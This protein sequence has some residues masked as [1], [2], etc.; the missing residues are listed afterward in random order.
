MKYVINGREYPAVDWTKATLG[1]HADMADI[2]GKPL[3]ECVEEDENGEQRLSTTNPKVLIAIL[4]LS[5]RRVDP[6]ATV[7]DARA[8]VPLDIEYVR[9]PGD[10]VDAGP[11]EPSATETGPVAS[12]GQGTSPSGGGGDGSGS[13]T[14]NGSGTDSSVSGAGVYGPETIPDASGLPPSSTGSR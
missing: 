14:S 1:E 2:I 12:D 7:A 9:E 6:T 5:M 13:A 4:W 3:L 8:I 11:P 10:E